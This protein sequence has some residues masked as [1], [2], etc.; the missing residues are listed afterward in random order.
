M[1]N[2]ILRKS[3]YEGWSVWNRNTQCRNGESRLIPH[4]Y[5]FIMILP[6]K[7]VDHTWF[8]ELD[9]IY[10][11]IL[12]LSVTSSGLLNFPGPGLFLFKIT[13]CQVGLTRGIK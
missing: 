9:T 11:Y 3:I 5:N 2:E 6:Y 7:A 4:F 1:M 12:G 8:L 13:L 10:V